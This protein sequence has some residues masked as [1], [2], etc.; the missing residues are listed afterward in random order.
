[1]SATFDGALLIE[2]A[3]RSVCLVR[4]LYCR[5]AGDV[6]FSACWRAVRACRLAPL[7]LR[8]AV[9]LVAFGLS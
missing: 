5:H 7:R 1:M 6:H 9:E 3:S 2:H 8:V 4:E